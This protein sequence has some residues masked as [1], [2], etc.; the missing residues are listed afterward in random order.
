LKF[1]LIRVIIFIDTRQLP[2]G[3]RMCLMW[4]S[5]GP[6]RDGVRLELSE[7]RTATDSL[8][9]RRL[10]SAYLAVLRVCKEKP[11]DRTVSRNKTTAGKLKVHVVN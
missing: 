9:A 1:L 5:V 2:D 4:G 3:D 10:W 11:T 7:L 8:S 6:Q